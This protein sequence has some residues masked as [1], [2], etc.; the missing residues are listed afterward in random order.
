LSSKR[1]QHP[2]NNKFELQ[3]LRHFCEKKAL[4]TF[5]GLCILNHGYLNHPREAEHTI[6]PS[7]AMDSSIPQETMMDCCTPNLLP[8]IQLNN[9][10]VYFI[11]NDRYE[12]AIVC[13]LT[14]FEHVNEQL[15]S[16]ISTPSTPSQPCST[17]H[18]LAAFFLVQDKY[19]S[20]AAPAGSQ[21]QPFVFRNPILISEDLNKVHLNCSDKIVLVA[22]NNLALSYHLCAT[23][24]VC[25]KRLEQA[26]LYYG[27]AYKML[28]AEPRVVVSQAMAILNN[29]GHIHRL[30][31]NEEGAKNCFQYL[32]STMMFVLLSGE[33][34][35]IH[36]WDS[37]LSNV[38]D[39]IVPGTLPASAA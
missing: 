37:F 33:S 22:T 25:K 3:I 29:I 20:S 19:S 2:A 15:E 17:M 21:Q 1:A 36:N 4:R 6:F 30:L 5:S 8:V 9:F 34:D 26:L 23:E 38:M 11:Q 18:S 32:L 12:E 14:I 35:R 24:S 13:F 16:E 31:N 39:L 27:Q 10:G 7:S 28:L